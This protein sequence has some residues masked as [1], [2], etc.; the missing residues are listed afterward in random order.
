MRWTLKRTGL[1]DH[2]F[3]KSSEIEVFEGEEFKKFSL[4]NTEVYL[5]EVVPGVL[6]EKMDRSPMR[7][8]IRASQFKKQRD[9]Q[10][11]FCSKF[12]LGKN[13]EIVEIELAPFVFLWEQNKVSELISSNNKVKS[14][15][16]GTVTALKKESGDKVL[17]GDVILIVE[18]MKM[19]NKIY[20]PASGILK[21]L[22]LALKENVKSGQVLFEIVKS[23]S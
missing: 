9:E 5:R 2:H 11:L 13:S 7:K 10:A 21:G 1:E 22:N 8:V 4:N 17:E 16:S 3:E 12:V 19:E 6:L 18:A 20:A 14:T 15:I 23:E